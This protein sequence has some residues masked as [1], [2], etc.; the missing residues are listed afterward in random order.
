MSDHPNQ[1]EDKTTRRK[2][3]SQ[4]SCPLGAAWSG[5]CLYKSPRSKYQAQRWPH[6]MPEIQQNGLRPSQA[7]EI[8]PGCD[9]GIW[10]L[11]LEHCLV[12]ACSVDLPK[13]FENGDHFSLFWSTIE[14]TWQAFL[15]IK[16]GTVVC[17]IVSV[18]FSIFVP[19]AGQ[20]YYC[21]S[22]SQSYRLDQI[23]RSWPWQQPIRV[24]LVLLHS[25]LCSIVEKGFVSLCLHF[26]FGLSYCLFLTFAVTPL[27]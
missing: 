25:H 21:I 10:H 12:T 27:F 11:T 17:D 19:R 1:C 22:R 15:P 2:W 16:F 7:A 3:D 9:W 8:F 6:Q 24:D 20:L 5:C 4:S 23:W 18:W 26:Y 13:W 14:Y